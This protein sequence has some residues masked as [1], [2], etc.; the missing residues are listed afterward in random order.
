MLERVNH[1]NGVVTY[2]SPRLR[3]AGVVHAFSARVG[4]VST[5]PFNSLNLGNPTPAAGKVA[6]DAAEH[7][8]ENYRRLEEAV[9][10]AGFPRAWVKQVHGTR[11]ELVEAEPESD[12][13]E[14]LESLIRDRFQGQL[15]A[16]ALITWQR[17][18]LLAVRIADCVPI[19]LA[20]ADGATV[21]A[22][23]AGWRGVANGILTKTLRALGEL[24]IGPDRTIA[25]IGPHISVEHFEVGPEVAW[26]FKQV[27]LGDAIVPPAVGGGGGKQHVDLQRALLMQLDA[28]HVIQVDTAEF[29]ACCTVSNAADFFSHRRDHGETGRMAAVI[30]AAGR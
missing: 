12:Y 6:P 29:P 28:A 24:G 25:A 13:S 21:A 27:G 10:A 3:T 8:A 5:A 4:G 17:N 7:L 1:A 18:V 15:E 19:L 14:T 20:S 11:V 2:Q 22:V 26:E 16:D 9:G 23:H 30:G